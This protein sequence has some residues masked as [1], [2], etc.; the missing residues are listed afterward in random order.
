VARLAFLLG[1]VLCTSA[2][3][4]MATVVH[5]LSFSFP[6]VAGRSFRCMQM[7]RRAQW[8]GWRSCWVWSR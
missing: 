7:R 4:N 1:V 2:L 8:R 5:T 3:T 6:T